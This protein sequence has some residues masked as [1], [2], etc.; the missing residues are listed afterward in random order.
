MV[1]KFLLVFVAVLMIFASAQTSQAVLNAVDPGP[2]VAA[3][4]NF[5]QWY[6]DTNATALELCLS[7]ATN[8]N[9]QLCTLLPD[10]GFDPAQLIVWPTNF[11]SES[12]WFTADAS[13]TS[14][15]VTVRYVAA[16]EAAFANGPVEPG[17]QV[18]FARI[19]IVANVTNPGTYVVTH[20]YGQE[21]F[22]V[23]TTGN[24]AVAFTRDVGFAP[25]SFTGALKGDIGP[26]LRAST[27]PITVGAEQFIG[28]PN[29]TQTVV[30]SPFG[31]NFLRIQGPGIDLQTN[32][33]F[34]MGKLYTAAV[35][36]TPLVIDRTSYSRNAA[37]TQIDVFATSAPAAVLSFDDTSVPAVTTLMGGDAIGRFFGQ[38]LVPPATLGPVTITAVNPPNATTVSPASAVTD[39]VF[40]T[41]AEYSIGTDTLVI[42]ASSSDETALPGMTATGFGALNT[43]LVPPTFSGSFTAAIPPATVTVTSAAGGADTEEVT[44]I[45]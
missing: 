28:D 16:L 17:A 1:R 3:F 8:V 38:A 18:S 6:Q 4:G 20:P 24:R 41:R 14:Q 26:F 15:A 36:P 21:V 10:P 5:P 22:E 2:Y 27:G 42:E 37:Q 30:G 11:P 33:F 9:G 29:V 23:P 32:Q 44:V 12:F 43:A 25:G 13:I 34:I 45:P 19:R 39:L 31:T 40:I 7:T 35:L